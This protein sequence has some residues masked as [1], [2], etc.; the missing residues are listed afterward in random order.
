ME[1][2]TIFLFYRTIGFDLS[3]KNQI[4]ILTFYL[5]LF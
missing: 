3:I 2:S 5:G 1:S 4:L